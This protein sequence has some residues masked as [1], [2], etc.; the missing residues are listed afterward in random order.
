MLH[1][2]YSL[3][4][5]VE[6]KETGILDG[7]GGPVAVPESNSWVR[8]NRDMLNASRY[9]ISKLLTAEKSCLA[10]LGYV[11]ND[12]ILIMSCGPKGPINFG[13]NMSMCRIG[14]DRLKIVQLSDGRL[15]RDRIAP[16][17]Q[18]DSTVSVTRRG[19]ASK[20]PHTIQ[21]SSDLVSLHTLHVLNH[22][23]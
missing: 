12:L 20:S 21:L 13:D 4:S 8:A 7:F 18:G 1:N 2:G 11:Y 22:A 5:Y 19:E 14:R 10:L 17:L 23:S 15:A 3:K 6:L 16:L 9:H